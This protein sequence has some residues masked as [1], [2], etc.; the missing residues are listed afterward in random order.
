MKPA[1]APA[2]FTVPT[3]MNFVSGG[4]GGHNHGKKW[5]TPITGV[6]V[7]GVLS[8]YLPI[9]NHT[10]YFND[11]NDSLQ[12][13]AVSGS[14]NYAYQVVNYWHGSTRIPK[15]FTSSSQDN[16]SSP[17]ATVRNFVRY[18]GS[19]F[20]T[21]D[22]N[23]IPRGAVRQVPSSSFGT[24]I[25]DITPSFSQYTNFDP[26]P[27]NRIEPSDDSVN[28]HI[29][30][31]AINCPTINPTQATVS[32]FELNRSGSDFYSIIQP[33]WW[34]GVAPVP[35]KV[36][37]EIKETEYLLLPGDELILGLESSNFATPDFG[38]LFMTGVYKDS[39]MLYG[40]TSYVKVLPGI[41]E[42]QLE[43][44][45]LRDGE[46]ASIQNSSNG[47]I[48]TVIGDVPYDQFLVTET[49]GY[50]GGIFDEIITGSIFS[51][52][53]PR[54]V[55]GHATAGDIKGNFSVNRFFTV[56]T[57]RYVRDYYDDVIRNT[58]R[59]TG[60]ISGDI[61]SKFKIPQK[62]VLSS[63]HYGY[64]RD[65]LETPSYQVLAPVTRGSSFNSPPVTVRFVEKGS[66]QFENVDEFQ[67]SQTSPLSVQGSS[68]TS[69]N[70]NKF[71]RLDGPFKDGE[72]TNRDELEYTVTV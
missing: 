30:G 3:L 49:D 9:W 18:I 32:T 5:N 12:H 53:N 72:F 20:R 26:D 65:F 41:G 47:D 39:T 38:P 70:V 29:D 17:S 55:A 2:G 62:A 43:G 57:D 8:H 33:G 56:Y 21:I 6:Y 19:R 46:T 27:R 54:G 4:I 48:S 66:T 22:A 60:S 11:S 58:L 7:T 31:R 36:G 15:F 64:L 61:T 63:I 25:F 35:K 67:K 59:V 68:T 13:F 24:S 44:R 40:P 71:S 10:G 23:D 1:V 52:T 28:I 45:F 16:S 14:G 34:Q 51:E 69:Q 42:L 37:P 50:Y